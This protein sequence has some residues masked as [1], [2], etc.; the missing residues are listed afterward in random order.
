AELRV[1]VVIRE[2]QAAVLVAHDRAE[3]VADVALADARE[4]RPLLPERAQPR[5]HRGVERAH[6]AGVDAH[7]LARLPAVRLDGLD[8]LVQRDRLRL[9]GANT[10]E[11]EPG[12]A[13]GALRLAE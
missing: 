10:L 3:D 8:P 11:H 5:Q 12:L 4:D 7:A 6:R 2:L 13:R 9:A 1:V